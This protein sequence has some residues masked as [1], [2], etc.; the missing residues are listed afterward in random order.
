M[1]FILFGFLAMLTPLIL[2]TFLS[3]MDG[4]PIADEAWR[5][6]YLENKALAELLVPVTFSMGLVVAII[7]IL[8]VATSKGRD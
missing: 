1:F 3:V 5:N 8:M 7:K 4:F 2:G 6:I